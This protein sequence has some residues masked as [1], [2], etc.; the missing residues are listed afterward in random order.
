[1]EFLSEDSIL[2]KIELATQTFSSKSFGSQVGGVKVFNQLQK[3]HFNLSRT[4]QQNSSSC[5][6]PVPSTSLYIQHLHQMA[7]KC[8][9]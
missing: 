8:P 7:L 1:M 9:R 3:I 6:C 5:K 4:E 2:P